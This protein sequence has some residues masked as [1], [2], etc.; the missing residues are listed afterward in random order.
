MLDPIT[1]LCTTVALRKLITVQSYFMK[2]TLQAAFQNSE[3]ISF[4]ELIHS[5]SQE[6]T[7]QRSLMSVRNKKKI[8]NMRQQQLIFKE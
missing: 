4:P 1:F 5:F 6:H 3:Q 2:I 7:F 8:K